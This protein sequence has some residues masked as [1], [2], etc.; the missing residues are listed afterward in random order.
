MNLHSTILTKFF[1]ILTVISWTGCSTA[2]KYPVKYPVQNM[3]VDLITLAADDMEGRATGTDGEYKAGNYI[4]GRLREVGLTPMGDRNSYFQTF[5]KK[6]KSNPHAEK[7]ADDDPEITGRNVIGYIDNKA[8]YTIIIGAH[9]DHLGWGEHGSLHTGE[10]AI[11]NGAD[12][13]ASGVTGLIF[14]AESLKKAKY[15]N[16]NYLFIAFSGEEMGLLGSNYFINNPTINLASVNYMINMDMIGRLKPESKLA[17]SG[18]GT[19]PVFEPVI[20][21][22]K[23]KELDIKKELSGSGPSDHMSFYNTGIPVLAFFTGQHEDYH[24][25][26]DDAHL[27]NYSGLKHVT[28]YIYNIIA[29]LDKK[30]KLAFAKTQDPIASTRAFSVTLGV[31]PDYLYDGRGMR[32]DGVRDDRPGQKAGLQKGDI[33]LKIGEL[34]IA[35][36]N[37]YMKALAL[38]KQGQTVDII[39]RR[40]DEDIVKSVTF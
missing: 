3:A 28:Q 32:I 27:I 36:I 25:P 34:D 30:G 40:N 5:T 18:V 29:G 9:Y 23:Y 37:S 38:F 17:I 24:K 35:D 11:H 7:P 31:M 19:S 39:I 14:L 12:D 15:K 33:I 8:P 16:N 22:I 20:D 1:I 6:I 10:K 21:G 26:S 13:N 4:A 2:V